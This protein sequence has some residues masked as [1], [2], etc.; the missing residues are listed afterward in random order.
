[1]RAL[2]LA[3]VVAS[4][5][6]TG[7][8]RDTQ[9]KCA[10]S[11]DCTGAG[12]AAGTCE[13][14]G[15]CSFADT[16]CADGRRYGSFSGSYS[17]QCVG[18]VAMGDAGVDG[19]MDDAP[20][21][22]NCPAGYTTLPSAGAHVYKLTSGAASWNTQRSR[23]AADGAYL[24]IPDDAA[25]LTAITTA[26]GAA[27]TWVGIT[28]SAAEDT[29]LTVNGDTPPY[30]PWDTANGEPNNGGEQDCVSALMASPNIASDRCG[31]S[32]PAVCECVP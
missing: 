12:G 22:S 14:T 8:L 25:E 18:A 20:T 27:R 13:T 10:T 30:L 23:C 32:F 24:A 9:F 19:P 1:M 3:I 11:A 4:G 28:D 29:F 2:W 15:Y 6:N 31:T 16:E 21:S 5:A 26:T 7:C 17:N